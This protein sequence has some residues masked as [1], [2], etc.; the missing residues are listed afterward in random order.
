MSCSGSRHVDFEK[1]HAAFLNHYSKDPKLGESRYADWVKFSGLDQTQSYYIQGAERELFGV[2]AQKTGMIVSLA[3]GFL[4][5]RLEPLNPNWENSVNNK[6]KYCLII[7]KKYL[8]L[9]LDGLRW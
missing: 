5:L 7:K 6:A 8:N 3:S 9:I 1:I 4:F 2:L